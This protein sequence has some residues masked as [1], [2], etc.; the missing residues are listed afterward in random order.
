MKNDL[1][2]LLVS[3]GACTDALEWAHGRELSPATCAAAKEDEDYRQWVID[4]LSGYGCGDTGYGV[5]YGEG[6]GYGGCYGGEGSGLGCGVDYGEGSGYGDG[7]GYGSG[8]VGYGTGYGIGLDI[9]GAG[10]GAGYR[11]GDGY[12]YGYSIS[13]NRDIIHLVREDG[14]VLVDG[15]IGAAPAEMVLGVLWW[16]FS[17]LGERRAS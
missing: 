1:F 7:A 3:L 4:Q 8:D 14:T 12:G 13:T 6:S 15:A 5:D 17:S 11:Y 9:H 16:L 2:W 10:S